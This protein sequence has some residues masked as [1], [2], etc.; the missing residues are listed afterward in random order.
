MRLAQEDS[1]VCP[2][3]QHFSFVPE[4]PPL[5]LARPSSKGTPTSLLSFAVG[6][7][8]LGAIS[9]FFCCFWG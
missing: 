8:L 3:F 1:V 2:G 7:N 9:H 6:R 5:S 4:Q